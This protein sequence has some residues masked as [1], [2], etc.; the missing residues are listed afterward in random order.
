MDLEGISSLIWVSIP[1][2]FLKL[3]EFGVL[4]WI[5]LSQLIGKGVQHVC[6]EG[7]YGRKVFSKKCRILKM[8]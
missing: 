7:R 1:F 8:P 5:D 2:I 4:H 6:Y 3:S